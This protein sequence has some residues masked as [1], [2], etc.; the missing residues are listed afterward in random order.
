VSKVFGELKLG[1]FQEVREGKEDR[2]CA[3]HTVACRIGPEDGTNNAV[4][5]KGEEKQ[6]PVTVGP[7]RGRTVCC[8]RPIT[9]EGRGGYPRAPRKKEEKNRFS[10]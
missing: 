9:R 5:E 6:R 2:N 10:L 7:Q 1:R 4:S 8:Q 3:K